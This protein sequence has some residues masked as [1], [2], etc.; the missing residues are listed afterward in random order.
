MQAPQ[1]R[2][3]QAQRE[4]EINLFDTWQIKLP[5]ND[6]WTRARLTAHHS[7]G[8]GGGAPAA[9]RSLR[10]TQGP[11]RPR[12]CGTSGRSLKKGG[13][14]RRGPA[15]GAAGLGGGGLYLS[16]RGPRSS[17]S[18]RNRNR[19]SGCARTPRPSPKRDPRRVRRGGQRVPGAAAGP[20][21]A[22][23]SE[24]RR[25]GSAPRGG[26][27]PWRLPSSCLRPAPLIPALKPNPQGGGIRW[28]E[29]AGPGRCLG[30][31]GR[32]PWMV[33]LPLDPGQRP[34]PPAPGGH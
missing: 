2:L 20:R 25:P 8:H 22:E 29:A 13:A 26:R 12:S 31:E 21:G 7:P 11:L 32:A 27:P 34:V 5:S 23:G 4:A 15:R 3:L 10:V 24:R 33:S 14:G 28:A 6:G 1:G 9:T 17:S 19:T 16:G 30:H 18:G